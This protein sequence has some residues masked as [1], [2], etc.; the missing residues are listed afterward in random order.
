[1]TD[2]VILPYWEFEPKIDD[3][4]YIFPHTTI[5]GDV[6]IGEH[7]SIWPQVVLRGD[8]HQIRIGKNTNLQDG[9][10]GHVTT[11]RH[12]LVIG[13]NVT[14]GHGAILHGCEV[15]DGALIG[16]GSRVLDGAVVEP[17]AMVA[18]GALVGP[19]KVV[20]SGMLWAGVPAKQMRPMNED[21]IAYLEW[22]ADHYVKLAA[23]YFGG[24][25]HPRRD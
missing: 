15:G 14:V 17:G 10:I 6:T 3:T 4:A 13:D 12:D 19:G 8:V 21:E 11:G 22:S 16:M 1:M 2:S 25:Y 18:A 24:N 9:A 5:M 23:S 20:P 7:T